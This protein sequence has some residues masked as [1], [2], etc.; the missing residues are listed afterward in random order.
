MRLPLQVTFRDIP[1]SDAIETHIT[2]KAAKM[3]RFYERIMSC[4]VVVDQPQRRHHKGKLYGVRVDITIPGKEIAVNR[5]ENEDVYV[6]LRDA[7][8][9]AYRILEEQRRKERGVVKT[10]EEVPSGRVAK[11]FPESEY[12]FI[13]TMDE[14]DVY[15]HR[16]SVLNGD[17]NKL[18]IGTAVSFREEQGQEGPQAMRVAIRKAA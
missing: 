6:A 18:K 17:F 16:N 9:A 10:H 4:R 13:R 3:D 15:F 12:G 5:S 7:F 14:R 11:L 1:P 8:D 2:E